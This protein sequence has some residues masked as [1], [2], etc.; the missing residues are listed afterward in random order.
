[1]RE[2]TCRAP[3]EQV[4]AAV[5]TIGGLRSWWTPITAGVLEVGGQV[6][7]G[8][9]ALEEAIVMGVDEL[10][11]PARVRWS[12]L[13]HTGALE[14]AG[15]SVSFYLT[16]HGPGTT[17]LTF[18]HTGLPGSSVAVGWDRFLSNLTRLVETG[19]G[20]PYRSGRCNALQVA[21][22]Y[23]DAW[24]G[25]D[26]D[27]ACRYLAP[28]LKTEV[29]I[30]AYAGRDDFADAVTRFAGFA[31]RVDLV[32]EFGS[33][34]Q[35]LLLYDMHT[36][37]LGRFRVAEHFTVADGLIQRIRQVHDTAPLRAAT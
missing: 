26:F 7:F 25:R 27:T 34:E 36:Q 29:P 4:F 21:R 37:Q 8:F 16:E 17:Q 19:Q 20:D 13:T 3:R 10:S 5:A 1:M 28:D 14:W 9:E 35:A 32:A 18:R 12:C 24:T 30:N 31:Q 22:A 15:T 23:H 11:F 33:G 2:V 6:V